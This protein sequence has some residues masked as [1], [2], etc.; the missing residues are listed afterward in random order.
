MSSPAIRLALKQLAFASRL[1]IAA[2]MVH[3]LLFVPRAVVD[4]K[5]AFQVAW[6]LSSLLCILGF[7][8]ANAH[9]G[10]NDEVSDFT[11]PSMAIGRRAERKA[12]LSIA[13][14]FYFSF[15]V[16]VLNLI[17]ALWTWF[18]IRGVVS[19]QKRKAADARAASAR[20]ESKFGPMGSGSR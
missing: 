13:L 4:P 15:L 14:M 3:L 5:L 1:L 17:V 2:M 20:R 10:L 9:L 6:F 16:P 19:E 7:M 11:K 18:R 8:I 12:R